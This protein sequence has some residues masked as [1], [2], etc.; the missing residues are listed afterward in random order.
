MFYLRG[1]C[2]KDLYLCYSFNCLIIVNYKEGVSRRKSRGS[3]DKKV[4]KGLLNT[5]KVK[6]IYIIA[7]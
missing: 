4:Y 2:P 5:Y 6:D 7:Y 1:Y 3:R